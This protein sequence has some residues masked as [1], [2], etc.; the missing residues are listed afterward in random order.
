MIFVMKIARCPK[1]GKLLTTLVIQ[2]S[3]GSAL[4]RKCWGQRG[5]SAFKSV[6]CSHRTTKS[7]YST[8]ARQLRTP[9]K[10]QLQGYLMPLSPSG[11]GKHESPFVMT[12]QGATYE[13][14]GD[15]KKGPGVGVKTIKV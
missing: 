2:L 12:E 13:E 9:C 1:H 5:G 14:K 8:H 7:V 15:Q 10:L 6:Y 3:G 11:T 4:M